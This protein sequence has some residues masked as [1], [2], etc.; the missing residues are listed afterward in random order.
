MSLYGGSVQLTGQQASR[1]IMNLAA[2]FFGKGVFMGKKLYV[3]GLPFET[4]ED[5]LSQIFTAA[6]QVVSAKLIVD[7]FSGQSRGFGFV[8]MSTDAES[9]NA[10]KTLNG[11]SVGS[12]KLTVNEARPMEKRESGGSFGAKSGGGGFGGGFGGGR[13]GYGGKGGGGGKGKK[14][15][16]FKRW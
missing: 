13:G 14:G 8:E 3:G 10:I 5:Q 11:F 9:D 12:R 4:T 7:K 15:G 16:S 6:G 2:L 1:E